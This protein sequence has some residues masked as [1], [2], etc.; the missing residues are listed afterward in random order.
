MCVVWWV[1]GWE[2]SQRVWSGLVN[3]FIVVINLLASGTW[4]TDAA[5]YENRMNQTAAAAAAAAA[6]R[7]TWTHWVQLFHLICHPTS[8][9]HPPSFSL[10]LRLLPHPALLT[11]FRL[12]Q[13]GLRISD[14]GTVGID[15]WLE[16]ELMNEI[17]GRRKMEDYIYSFWRFF[18]F[19]WMSSSIG[20]WLGSILLRVR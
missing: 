19:F 10:P 4:H 3:K 18:F 8:D 13:Q 9:L 6:T 5:L 17:A 20:N 7:Q 14:S 16:L 12:K 2:N 11:E 1:G 15:S